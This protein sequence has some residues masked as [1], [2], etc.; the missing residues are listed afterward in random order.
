MLAI[1]APSARELELPTIGNAVYHG[2]VEKG[3]QVV[4][5]EV[6]TLI[7]T[8]NLIHRLYRSIRIADESALAVHVADFN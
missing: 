5:F 7:A 4:D 2:E 8:Y 6:H 3:R 1:I